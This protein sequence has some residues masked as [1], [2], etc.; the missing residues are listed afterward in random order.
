[1]RDHFFGPVKRRTAMNMTQPRSRVNSPAG[2]AVLALGFFGVVFAVNGVLVRA[3]TST[4][5]GVE[6]AELLQGRPDVR[7]AKS[8]AA[9]RQDALRLAGRRQARARRGRRGRARCHACATRKARAARRP[10]RQTRRLAHPA[11]ARLDHALRAQ[12]RTAR[13]AFP[14]RRP[15][16]RRAS[17]T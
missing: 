13:G 12:P 6:T 1:M 4:F 14:R 9:E 10:R 17:G 16:A 2:R 15:G 7:A 8:A 11:D 5:G 3:A